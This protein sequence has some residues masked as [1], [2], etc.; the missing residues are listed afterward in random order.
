MAESGNID[1]DPAKSVTV[2]LDFDSVHWTS[3]DRGITVVQEKL[4]LPVKTRNDFL[5][6]LLTNAYY[7][8]LALVQGA[9]EVT[10]GVHDAPDEF[11]EAESVPGNSLPQKEVGP[12]LQ[13]PGYAAEVIQ[14]QFHSYELAVDTMQEILAGYVRGDPLKLVLDTGTEK[15]FPFVT[16]GRFEAPPAP[17]VVH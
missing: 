14:A 13:I 17:S 4:H 15:Q 10:L 11:I 8:A 9:Q 2:S 7:Y 6:F 5:K 16:S 12:P 1:A 3:V